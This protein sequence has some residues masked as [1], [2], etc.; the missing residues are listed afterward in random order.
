MWLDDLKGR[1]A[2]T[3]AVKTRNVFIESNTEINLQTLPEPN[4]IISAEQ[5]TAPSSPFYRS[6][7]IRRGVLK[8][9]CDLIAI[10]DDGPNH[11]F[12]LI[13]AKSGSDTFDVDSEKA[14]EQLKSSLGILDTVVQGCT[15]DLP[16]TDLSEC[17]VR[18]ACVMEVMRGN[19][20]SNPTQS[21]KTVDFYRATGVRLSYVGAD[22]DIWQAIQSNES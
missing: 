20:P 22:E 4:L 1:L 18:A 15:I 10:S 3:G 16:F 6:F 17:D 5:L 14:F 19:R 7:H 8:K 13:E 11:L 9:H 2:P 12:V 21:D